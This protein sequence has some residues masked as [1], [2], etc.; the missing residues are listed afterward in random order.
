MRQIQIAFLITILISPTVDTSAGKVTLY[1]TYVK[2]APLILL[3]SILDTISYD[4]KIKI[5]KVVIDFFT[6]C[7]RGTSMG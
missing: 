4:K 6:V 7:L 1:K 5:S 3:Y 2:A